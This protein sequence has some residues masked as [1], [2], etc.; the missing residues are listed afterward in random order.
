MQVALRKETFLNFVVILDLFQ[1]FFANSLEQV[2][3]CHQLSSKS[4]SSEGI[5]LIKHMN[6]F[7]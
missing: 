7:K 3:A 1:I 4:E 6:H 5:N 2:A